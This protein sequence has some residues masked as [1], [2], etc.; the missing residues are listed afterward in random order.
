VNLEFAPIICEESEIDIAI[1]LACIPQKHID[2]IVKNIRAGKAPHELH[3]IY[4]LSRKHVAFILKLDAT[5]KGWE[6][7]MIDKPRKGE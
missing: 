4:E 6:R 7:R 3:P 5:A 2:I 1:D